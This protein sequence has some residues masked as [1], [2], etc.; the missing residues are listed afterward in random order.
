MSGL[1]FS[2][3]DA[4][5]VLLVRAI[6]SEDLEGVALTREDRRDVGAAALSEAPLSSDD[7]NRQLRRF[8]VARADRALGRL[9]SRYPMLRRVR[10]VAR[11]PGWAL[12]SKA[13]FGRRID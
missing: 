12:P 13:R 11:W 5:S 9:D 4:A 1:R 2:E 6:E 8:L 10:D 3:R 7:D